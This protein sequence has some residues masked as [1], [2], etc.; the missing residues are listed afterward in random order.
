M[1]EIERAIKVEEV[2]VIHIEN[3][4]ASL[5][6]LIKTDQVFAEVFTVN[7]DYVEGRG[8][9]VNYNILEKG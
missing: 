7:T 6:T 4:I 5:S 3:L 2:L 1:H 8:L 9:D